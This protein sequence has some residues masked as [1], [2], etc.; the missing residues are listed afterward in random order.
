MGG[1]YV[2]V[3]PEVE[4][5]KD[6]EIQAPITDKDTTTIKMGGHYVEVKQEVE[7]EIK[8]D[9]PSKLTNEEV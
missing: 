8:I 6:T 3:K 4:A 7:T 1:Q 9:A 5:N 2:E